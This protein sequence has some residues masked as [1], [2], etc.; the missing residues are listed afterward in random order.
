MLPA[1][2]STATAEFSFAGFGPSSESSA[3]RP[4][5]SLTTVFAAFCA[6]HGAFTSACLERW[7]QLAGLVCM[8]Q[9]ATG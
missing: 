9:H 6:S 7:R 4:R 5:R 3:G 2:K 8:P 1:W